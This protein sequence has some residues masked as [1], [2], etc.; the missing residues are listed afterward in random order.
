MSSGYTP[1]SKPLDA[2]GQ[3]GSLLQESGAARSQ[4]PRSQQP[5]K[6]M[7]TSVS[8]D[9]P[10]K[11]KTVSAIRNVS[12]QVFMGVADGKPPLTW[13]NK[14]IDQHWD[15][16]SDWWLKFGLIAEKQEPEA[17]ISLEPMASL[18]K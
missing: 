17:G 11:G 14:Q 7:V 13:E 10:L 18:V 1:P 15:L 12:F 9:Y 4:R 3:G 16:T 8:K 2:S 6:L 5:A